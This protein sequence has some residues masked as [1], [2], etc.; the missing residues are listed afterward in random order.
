GPLPRG[1]DVLV[2]DDAYRLALRPYRDVEHGGDAERL[3][4]ARG[5]FRRRGVVLCVV[6][7]HRPVLQHGGEIRWV[8]RAGNAPAGEIVLRPAA[9]S[10]VKQLAGDRRAGRLEAPEAHALDVERAGVRGEDR[11]D[12]VH[13]ARLV[14]RGELEQHVAVAPDLLGALVDAA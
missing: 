4:V 14:E 13:A 1:S 2:A 5:E 3:Q 9:G 8:V 12:R 11:G 10:R 6:R 7:H